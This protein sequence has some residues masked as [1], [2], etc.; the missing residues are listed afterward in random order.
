MAAAFGSAT[1]GEGGES[2]QRGLKS[3]CCGG[4][5]TWQARLIAQLRFPPPQVPRRLLAR[6]VP[7]LVPSRDAELV[8]FR[9]EHHDVTELLA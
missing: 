4:P 5:S 2:I 3:V 8:A 9:V 1:L 6:L 7:V